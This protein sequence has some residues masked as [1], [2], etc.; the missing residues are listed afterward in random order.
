MKLPSRHYR[1]PPSRQSRPATKWTRPST[2]KRNTLFFKFV[3]FSPKIQGILRNISC[4]RS[5]PFESYT[6]A[7]VRIGVYRNARDYIRWH[8]LTVSKQHTWE[9]CNNMNYFRYLIVFK[10]LI[11]TL[12]FYITG[13]DCKRKYL[14]DQLIHSR[15]LLSLNQISAPPLNA[16]LSYSF[17]YVHSGLDWTEFRTSSAVEIADEHL[18][19]EARTSAT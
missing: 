9:K 15:F 10:L 3:L 11:Q 5:K 14:S 6:R 7:Q 2:S 12:L 8:R 13:I 17:D 16:I 4:W 18:E 1:H 19:V